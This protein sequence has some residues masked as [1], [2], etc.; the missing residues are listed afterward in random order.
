VPLKQ[1]SI[2]PFSFDG[3]PKL[4]LAI[5]L[6]VIGFGLILLMEKLAVKKD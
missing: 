6:A 1:Q 3:D 4:M 5:I 2:S